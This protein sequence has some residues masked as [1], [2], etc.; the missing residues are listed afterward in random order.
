MSM[1]DFHIIWSSRY[2]WKWL[3][4]VFLVIFDR[5]IICSRCLCAIKWS[6]FH[7]IGKWCLSEF[8]NVRGMMKILRYIFLLK[9]E[10]VKTDWGVST[11]AFAESWKGVCFWSYVSYAWRQKSNST[12]W[13]FITDYKES[14]RAVNGMLQWH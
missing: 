11:C 7:S 4:L 14:S 6:A 12:A 13:W 2:T 5:W 3:C 10:V 9:C 8:P 1:S